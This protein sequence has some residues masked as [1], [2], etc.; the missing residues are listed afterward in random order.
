VSKHQPEQANP[1]ATLRQKQ[2]NKGLT[3]T[4]KFHRTLLMHETELQ[5]HK[6]RT[7]RPEPMSGRA[8]LQQGEELQETIT[9]QSREP[10]NR[11]QRKNKEQAAKTKASRQDWH[12]VGIAGWACLPRTRKN[13]PGRWSATGNQGKTFMKNSSIEATG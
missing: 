2:T 8:K 10:E 9:H 12:W 1:Q 7:L 3:A 5:K 13:Q 4:Y 6:G 11:R